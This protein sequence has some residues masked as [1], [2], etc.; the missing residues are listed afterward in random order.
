MYER[1]IE[2]YKIDPEFY[3]LCRFLERFME[4]QKATPHDIRDATFIASIRIAQR[5]PDVFIDDKKI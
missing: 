3:Q 1:L 2:R 4:E 5:N